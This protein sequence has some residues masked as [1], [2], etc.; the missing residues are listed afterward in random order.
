MPNGFSAAEQPEV[1][2]SVVERVPV[3]KLLSSSRCKTCNNPD[4]EDNPLLE[5]YCEI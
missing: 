2:T 4:T 1:N 5:G 3:G